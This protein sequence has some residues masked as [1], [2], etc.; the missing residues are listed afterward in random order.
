VSVPFRH[1]LLVAG[2]DLRGLRRR[3]EQ[4]LSLLVFALLLLVVFHFAFDFSAFEF[5]TLGPG[6]LWAAVLF[7]GVLALD[8]SFRLEREEDRIDGLLMAPI[9]RSAI[10]GGKLLANVV[11]MMLVAAILTPLSAI[12]FNQPLDVWLLRLLPAAALNIVGIAAV[13]TLFAA[14]TTQLRQGDR[15]LPVLLFPAAVPIALAA[16]RSTSAIVA[17][18]P[19]DRY[20][21][22]LMLSLAYDLVFLAAAVLLFDYVLQD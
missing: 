7:S 22:W 9:D 14:V 18:R 13:G 17:G 11:V 6:V 10:Y 2:K 19:L 15:L 21:H 8:Q 4:I 1:A 16:V 20:G 5:A 3:P 12:F